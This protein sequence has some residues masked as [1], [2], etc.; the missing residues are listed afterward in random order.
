MALLTRDDTDLLTA[1]PSDSVKKP[2]HARA[3]TLHCYHLL[4][5][6]YYLL[7]ATR[8]TIEPFSTPYSSRITDYLCLVSTLT[9]YPRHPP[10][11]PRTLTSQAHYLF[12][13]SPS[14][15]V[16]ERTISALPVPTHFRNGV[17]TPEDCRRSVRRVRSA[18]SPAS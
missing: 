8:D 4:L 13:D 6:L 14:T 11:Q 5:L 15:L 12:Y 16:A 10:T 7:N 18:F 3:H 1:L 9:D 17:G 2:A